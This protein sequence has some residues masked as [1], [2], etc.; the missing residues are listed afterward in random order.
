M[1][2]RNAQTGQGEMPKQVLG[3]QA[4]EKKSV[5][6]HYLNRSRIQYTLPQLQHILLISNDLIKLFTQNKI[7]A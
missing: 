3:H 1:T 7:Y 6:K 4:D 5:N 2:G